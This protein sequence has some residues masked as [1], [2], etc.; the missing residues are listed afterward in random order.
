MLTLF[1]YAVGY[2]WKLMTA[3]ITKCPACKSKAGYYKE[4]TSITIERELFSYE[5]N[6][7]TCTE[8]FSKKKTES[9]F[10]RCA[11]CDSPIAKT[12]SKRIKNNR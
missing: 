5:D 9:E 1:T 4:I 3:H 8:I 2:L 12:D 7:P 6:E 10:F 11:N